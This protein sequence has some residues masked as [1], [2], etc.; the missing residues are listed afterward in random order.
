VNRRA[1]HRLALIPCSWLRLPR[2][3][4]RLRLTLLYSGLF[5]VC[6]AGLLALTYLLVSRTTTGHVSFAG[7][8]VSGQESFA[9]LSSS[10]S[11]PA[12][13]HPGVKPGPFS[14]EQLIGE[15]HLQQTSDLHHL[16]FWS[17]ITLALMTVVSV[18]LGYYVAGKVL[19]PI[20][21]ITYT[22]RMISARNLGQ[23]LAMDGPDDEFKALGDTLD[24]LFAR[25]QA[26]FDSQ[27]HF[28]ANASHEL[29]TP[30]SWERSLVE[31]ALADPHPTIE[32]FRDMCDELLAASDQQ[33]RLIDGLL[34]LASSQTALENREPVDLQELTEQALLAQR[35]E[36]DRQ[37]LDLR[38]TIEPA[39]AKGDPRLVER[40]ITNLIQNAVQHNRPGG[41]IE[42]TTTNRDDHAVLQ[43]ANTGQTIRPSE[44]QRLFEPFQR[45]NGS[46]TGEE[47]RYGLG[48]SI[49]RAI[50]TAHNATLTAEPRHTGGL[51]VEVIF[52]NDNVDPHDRHLRAA[53]GPKHHDELLSSARSATPPC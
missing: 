21:T 46:R 45:L 38:A 51:A 20:R 32:S 11:G 28:V 34:T 39:T 14:A 22:A 29:R 31:V 19:R 33:Q 16:L 24:D 53:P 41:H 8:G 3:T 5:L 40:L 50:A 48:L 2:Q 25:L 52:P 6:G 1:D 47:D 9:I 12:V 15:A 7:H 43:V 42:I 49:V 44:L 36:I 23:R 17:V 18:A 27:R 13:H 37:E 10:G 35:H 30:L 26:A 4:A